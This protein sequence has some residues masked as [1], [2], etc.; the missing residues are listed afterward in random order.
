MRKFAVVIAITM[1]ASLLLA[2]PA[3]AQSNPQPLPLTSPPGNP[4]CPG[5]LATRLLM[6]GRGMIAE[7]FSTL[8]DAPAGIEIQTIN[9]PAEFTV[10]AGPVSD[11]FLCYFQVLYDNG[12]TGWVV[13]SQVASEW[14]DNMYWLAPIGAPPP[15]LEPVNPLCPGGLV[16]Q[17]SIGM[18]GYVVSTYSTLRDAPGGNPIQRVYSPAEFT[19]IGGPVSDGYLCYF[20]LLY[21]DASTGWASESQL[22]SAWGSNKYWLAPIT[23]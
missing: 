17:L 15:V 6:G 9:A 4:L 5:S 10:L 19:V 7:S 14:G 3:G 11:G 21:D 12:L 13:E 16:N 8:Y 22:V 1:I 2:L 23:S 18:R 20:Q